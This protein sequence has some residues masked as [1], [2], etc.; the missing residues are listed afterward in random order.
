MYARSRLAHR[1]SVLKM[2]SLSIPS[3][4]RGLY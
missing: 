3:P 1:I 4:I 2:L